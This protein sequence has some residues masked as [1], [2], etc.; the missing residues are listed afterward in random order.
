MF[1]KQRDWWVS[2]GLRSFPEEEQV[3]LRGGGVG[4]NVGGEVEVLQ[5]VELLTF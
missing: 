3:G 1:R 4:S 2:S 5:S